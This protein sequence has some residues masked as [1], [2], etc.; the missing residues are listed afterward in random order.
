MADKIIFDAQVNLVGLE[1]GLLEPLAKV[2]VESKKAADNITKNLSQAAG[3][4][5]KAFA[6]YQLNKQFKTVQDAAKKTGIEIKSIFSN[7]D[8]V[9][10]KTAVNLTDVK[11]GIEANAAAAIKANRE[12]QKLSVASPNV[13]KAGSFNAQSQLVSGTQTSK[14]VQDASKLA[15]TFKSAKTELRELVN[16]ISSGKLSGEPL[17][18]AI[19]RSAELK[20]NISNTNQLVTALGSDTKGIDSVITAAQGLTAAFAVAAGAVSLFTDDEEAAAE[21][22]QKV[23]ASLSLLLGVQ[24]LAKIATDKNALAIGGL[25]VAEKANAVATGLATRTMAFF[26]VTTTATA[27]SFKLLRGAIIATGIGALIVL[28]GFVVDALSSASDE[29]NA[30]SEAQKDLAK[31]TKESYRELIVAEEKLANLRGTLSDTQLKRNALLRKGEDDL[32]ASRESAN[33]ALRNIDKEVANQVGT[34]ER[35]FRTLAEDVGLSYLG[36]VDTVEEAQAKVRA[37]LNKDVSAA[38]KEIR[39]TATNQQK[40]LAA[41]LAA[42]EIQEGKERL[43]RQED[44][45]KQ[46]LNAQLAAERAR[47]KLVIAITKEGSELNQGAIVALA[48]FELTATKKLLEQELLERKKALKESGVATR[49]DYDA[50]N[51]EISNRRKLTEQETIN[52][53]NRLNNEYRD[54]YFQEEKDFQEKLRQLEIDRLDAISTARQTAAQIERDRENNKALRRTTPGSSDRNEVIKEQIREQADAEIAVLKEKNAFILDENNALDET[55][56]ANARLV[57]QEIQTIDQNAKDAMHDSDVEFYQQRADL[58]LSTFNNVASSIS[59]IQNNITQKRIQDLDAQK[60]VE[61][62]NATLTAQQRAR[63]E[64]KYAAETKKLQQQ[65]AINDKNSALFQAFVNTAVGV[66]KALSS[67]NIPL[68]IIIAASGAL[69][70]AAIASRPIP[71]FKDGVVDYRGIGS[72]TSDENMV[73]I[74]RRESVMNARATKSL[75]PELE[76]ANKSPRDFLN[77]IDYK[78]VQPRLAATELERAHSDSQ[79]L[80]SMRDRKIEVRTG[81]LEKE[82]RNSRKQASKDANGIIQAIEK[83]HSNI[84]SKW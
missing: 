40:E 68:S 83:D 11:R 27:T 44:L 28:L 9:A 49:A 18:Q 55:Q 22:T 78:Y 37:S 32:A 4:V 35:F 71:K 15:T 29:T 41:E 39:A 56:L 61:L 53:V 81:K 80:P 20:N 19:A 38:G 62:S 30:F 60:E 73:M 7:T 1:E 25:S 8:E 33:E 5:G 47:L 31:N 74:S 34:T 52:E 77:L 45:S 66:T 69:E 57:A 42:L 67:A 79:S 82:V 75:T 43:K 16:L 14:A 6:S 72:E 70:L 26:G 50:L 24:Q 59:Q 3:N 21:A 76:A 65:Q 63:I 48:E 54:K 13:S 17:Q 84:R 46:L 23:Q 58:A 51:A 2:S 10:A 36:L 12:I 64:A